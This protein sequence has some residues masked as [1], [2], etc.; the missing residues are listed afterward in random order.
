MIMRHLARTI[1]AAFTIANVAAAFPAHAATSTMLPPEKTAA[2]IAY[3]TGGIGEEEA[4]AMKKAESRYPLVLEFVGKPVARGLNAEYLADVRVTIADAKDGKSV[5]S[6]TAAG[7]F[8]MAKVAPGKYTVTAEY[9][10]KTKH[11]TVEVRAKK[12]EHVMFEWNA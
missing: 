12:T 8:L 6:T 2:G 4:A 7:P 3:R 10:G 11:R 1:A 9:Q 5:L